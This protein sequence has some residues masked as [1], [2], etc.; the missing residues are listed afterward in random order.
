[1][2]LFLQEAFLA[3]LA[4]SHLSFEKLLPRPGFSH[5]LFCLGLTFQNII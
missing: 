1:M 3:P 4:H 5:L 2:H